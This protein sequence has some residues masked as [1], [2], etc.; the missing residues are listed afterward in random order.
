MKPIEIIESLVNQFG[1]SV[2]VE[3][4]ENLRERLDS[5]KIICPQCGKEKEIIYVCKN[6]NCPE[7]NGGW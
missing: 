1:D 3:A 5:V 4:W 2:D 7:D 6:G